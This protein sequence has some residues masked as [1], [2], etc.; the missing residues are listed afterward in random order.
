MSSVGNVKI[1]FA[2]A[3]YTTQEVNLYQVSHLQ[4]YSIS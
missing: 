3:K 1:D 4:L 2:L